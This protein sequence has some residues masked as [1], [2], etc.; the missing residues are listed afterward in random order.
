[1]LCCFFFFNDTPT[2]E[3]YTLSLHD[4]FRSTTNRPDFDTCRFESRSNPRSFNCVA[5]EPCCTPNWGEWRP[6]WL[7][8]IGSWKLNHQ[9]S[10][11]SR[12]DKCARSSNDNQFVDCAAVFT[13]STIRPF[14]VAL[15]RPLFHAQTRS[16]QE[17]ILA[18]AASDPASVRGHGHAG[19]HRSRHASCLD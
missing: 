6:R 4:V 18:V 8:W 7:I 14:L 5:C 16:P 13:I 9:D 10:I 1:M 2:P 3:I 11:W 12:C 17:N 15:E 19:V